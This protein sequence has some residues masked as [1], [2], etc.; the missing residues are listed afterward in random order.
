MVSETDK[1]GYQK[2]YDSWITDAGVQKTHTNNPNVFSETIYTHPNGIAVSVIQ[3]K[4]QSDKI[5]LTSRLN[6]PP[7]LRQ[8]ISTLPEDHQ[9]ALLNELKYG[10][11]QM[12]AQYALPMNDN[13]LQAVVV[14]R[15]TFGDGLTKQ[16]FFDNLYRVIDGLVFAQIKVQ[17]KL[18][19][20]F[21]RASNTN[22]YG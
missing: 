14:E 2:R 18:G 19:T 10:L 4:D 6:I 7:D 17:E 21:G 9:L 16:V 13:L 11:L 12:G 15:T 3:L 22:V 5:I 20:R 8:S 1:A